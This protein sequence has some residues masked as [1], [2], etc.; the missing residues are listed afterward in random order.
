MTDPIEEDVLDPEDKEAPQV[1][2]PAE[3]NPDD[4]AETGIVE[5]EGGLE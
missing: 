1:E 5:D 3:P 2:E 4:E